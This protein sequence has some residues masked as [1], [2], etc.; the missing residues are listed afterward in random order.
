M[1][2]TTF[3]RCE[4][5]AG[6]HEEMFPNFDTCL[7]DGTSFRNDEIHIYHFIMSMTLSASLFVYSASLF[8]SYL[9]SVN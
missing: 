3:L 8:L 5:M 9:N 4:E 2:D 1:V 7:F 6:F